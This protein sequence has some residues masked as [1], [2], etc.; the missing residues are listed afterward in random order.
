MDRE[1]MYCKWAKNGFKNF[2]SRKV[3]L[4]IKCIVSG[5]WMVGQTS[6]PPPSHIKKFFDDMC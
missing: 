6:I 5:S 4:K 2:F 3:E 1:E